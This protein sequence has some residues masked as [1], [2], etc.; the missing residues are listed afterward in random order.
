MISGLDEVPVDPIAGDT[1]I[2]A[3]SDANADASLDQL[4]DQSNTNSQDATTTGTFSAAPTFNT[5]A[6][7]AGDGGD[8]AEIDAGIEDVEVEVDQDQEDIDQTND[9]DQAGETY[10]TAYSGYVEVEQ[11]LGG[12]LEAG[13]TGIEAES[14]AEAVAD[15]DQLAFQ[16]NTNSQT[17][18]TNLTFT[19]N[20]T[21][22]TTTGDANAAMRTRRADPG[23][24]AIAAGDDAEIDAGIED[25]EVE[26]SQEQEDIDQ[27]N[28]AE[29]K[30]LWNEETG[31]WSPAVASAEAYSGAV[32]VEQTGALFAGSV[33]FD[34]ITGL[35]ISVSG[36]GID[37]KATAEADAELKQQA[38]QDNTNSQTATTNLA[39]TATPTFNTVA[40]AAADDAEI[41][42]GIEDVE[43]ELEQ[44]QED[45]D[46]ENE[47]DQYAVADAYS[48]YT[49]F[50]EAVSVVQSGTLEA[51]GTG[52]EAEAR[53][54]ANAELDQIAVQGNENSQTATPTASFTA[55]PTFGTT[56]GHA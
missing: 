39:F 49:G 18:T 38:V 46:Q 54:E 8:D 13:D 19:A 7:A 10:A 31:D 32:T 30:G 16:S 47:A 4:A 51:A 26:V 33:T 9:A 15:L 11:K 14:K 23:G 5:V 48:A 34:P 22:G 27:S 44:E 41:G 25:V 12:T 52:I 53:S 56:T 6:I 43:V 37:A 3:A 35:P 29:Q 1:G 21:F 45:I 2:D 55:A 40:I 17:A 42:A 36:D 28:E 20:P 50:G 24:V